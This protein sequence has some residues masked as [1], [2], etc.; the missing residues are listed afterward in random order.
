MPKSIIYLFFIFGLWFVL[1][2][3]KK[4]AGAND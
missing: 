3:Y 1:G 2:L 4:G